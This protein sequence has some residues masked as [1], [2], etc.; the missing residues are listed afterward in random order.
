MHG[1]SGGNTDGKLVTSITQFDKLDSEPYKI[2]LSRRTSGLP[3]ETLMTEAES[4]L[5][6]ELTFRTHWS[7]LYAPISDPGNQTS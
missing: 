1:I 5:L 4:S 2:C 7:K 6:D 3:S